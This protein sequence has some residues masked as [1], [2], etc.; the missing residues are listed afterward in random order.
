M[1]AEMRGSPVRG[2]P[3]R[4]SEVFEA[5]ERIAASGESPTIERVRR[6]LGR[7]SNSTIA[8]FLREWHA[9]RGQLG[10][11]KSLLEDSPAQLGSLVG[12]I[13]QQLSSEARRE[14]DAA[15]AQAEAICAAL[16]LESAER[17]TEAQRAAEQWQRQAAEAHEREQTLA[18][19]N[20]LLKQTQT[21]LIE[22]IAAVQRG[23]QE[24]IER[25]GAVLLAL[26][27]STE[28]GRAALQSAVARLAADS[29]AGQRA[30]GELRGESA[31]RSETLAVALRELAH[32]QRSA[33]ERASRHERWLSR[34][35][36]QAAERSHAEAE[37]HG[38][39]AAL[40]RA[41][42]QSEQSRSE[43]LVAA[44]SARLQLAGLQCE[45][46]CVEIR[47]GEQ[48]AALRGR[49]ESAERDARARLRAQRRMQR[50]LRQPLDPG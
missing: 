42:Q 15:R 12:R 5:A 19:E 48:L 7:G 36:M 38:H 29:A 34:L 14:V 21:D 45:S 32:G 17:E 46:Q 31:D 10:A 8:P 24:G 47:H 20:I 35:A 23:Q 33:A 28:Q 44:R 39:L 9:A 1:M 43:A 41:L 26:R 11:P 25:L 2:L 49:C 13:A 27:E 37:Q 40:I 6:D 30:L 4:E 3:V 16:R 18:S 50:L 22:Q